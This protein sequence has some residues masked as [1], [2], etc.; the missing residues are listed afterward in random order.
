MS[1]INKINDSMNEFQE[2]LDKVDINQFSPL[3][4]LK[5]MMAHFEMVEKVKPIYLKYLAANNNNSSF[6]FKL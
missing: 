1:D 2:M 5:I 4:Q 3:D 6:L